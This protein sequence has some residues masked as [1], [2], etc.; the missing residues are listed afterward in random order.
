MLT[1]FIAAHN[2]LAQISVGGV[3]AYSNDSI[4]AYVLKRLN[5][6][7]LIPLLIVAFSIAY[8]LIKKTITEKLE[9]LY[10]LFA[11][12]VGFSALGGVGIGINWF[13]D[14]FI[15][16]CLG[17]GLILSKIKN[18]K[19]VLVVM[20]LLITPWLFMSAKFLNDKIVKIE[21]LKNQEAGLLSDFNYLKNI[22]GNAICETMLICHYGNKNFIYDP[23]TTRELMK[24]NPEIEAQGIERLRLGYYKIIQLNNKINEP[25]YEKRFTDNFINAISKYYKLDRESKNGYYYIYNR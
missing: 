4:L 3:L 7:Y 2:F 6:F 22:E 5:P 12:F 11:L 16:G 20:L 14:S 17:I 9:V 18:Q 19:I 21:A 25:V 1:Y 8:L 10:L 23:G 13:F 24:Q 15:A